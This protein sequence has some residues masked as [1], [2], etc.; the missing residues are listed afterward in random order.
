MD[1]YWVDRYEWALIE[2]IKILMNDKGKDARLC[3]SSPSAI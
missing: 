1:V 3:T 2:K